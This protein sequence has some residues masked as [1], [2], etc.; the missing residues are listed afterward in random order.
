V[1]ALKSERARMASFSLEHSFSQ[2][3]TARVETYYKRLSDVLVGRL[4]TE[5][6]RLAR[7][8]PYRFPASLSAS[9]PTDAIITTVP[10]NDGRG[11]AYGFDVL[12]SRMTAPVNARLR[13]WVSYTWGRAER[14]A[15]GRTYPFEY[16]R[17]HAVSAVLSYRATPKWEFASTIRWATGFPRTAPVG[18]RVAG[19][20]IEVGSSE[21]IVPKFINGLPV[22]QVNY[23]G[24][25]NLNASRLPDF[26]RADVRATWKPRGANGRWE[27][28]AEVINVLNRKNAGALTA[29]LA[30]DPTSDR[31]KIVEKADQSIP[32]LPTIGLRWK[33]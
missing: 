1:A 13:G 3:F 19:Q 8:A 10:T 17:R 33:F 30:Y 6:E 31:P 21:F 4:E 28:Y 22:Y 9:L 23:G 25:A 32:L 14:E 2:G 24:V 5:T 7:L 11:R 27:F 12:V 26:A 29:E 16:D 18:I 20:T 15:Y